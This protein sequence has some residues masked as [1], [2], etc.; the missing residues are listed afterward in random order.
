VSVAILFHTMANILGAAVPSWTT[1]QGRWIGFAVLVM[2]AGVIVLIWGPRHLNRSL[3]GRYDAS[4][5]ATH[6]AQGT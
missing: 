5:G 6:P 2:F 4:P 1:D 3:P